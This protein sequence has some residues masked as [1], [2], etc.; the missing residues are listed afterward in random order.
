M[1]QKELEL[2]LAALVCV[3]EKFLNLKKFLI[4]L[5]LIRQTVKTTSWV[6]HVK[7]NFLLTVQKFLK[8]N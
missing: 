3:L 5:Q 4:D 8:L 6:V 1:Q 7:Q 2:R